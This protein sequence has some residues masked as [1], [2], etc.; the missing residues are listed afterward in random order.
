VSEPVQIDVR[1][2]IAGKSPALLRV[3][4]PVVIRLLE[5]II[6]SRDL[7]RGLRLLHDYSGVEFARQTLLL[8]GARVETIGEEHVS[9]VKRPLVVAN[10]PLGGLDGLALIDVVGRHHE[11]VVLPVNDLL[12]NIPQLRPVF[13]PINKHGSNRAYREKFDLAFAE[14][15]AVVHFPAGLCSRRK[16]DRIRDLDWQKSFVPRARQ[17]ERTIVPTHVEGA[18]S[19]FFYNL[20]RLRRWTGLR[21]NIEM[22]FL[23]HE[24][25]RQRGRTIRI[26]FGRP[27]SAGELPS[28][29]DPWMIARMLK[30]HVYRLSEDPDAVFSP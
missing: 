18:N 22:I 11:L 26:T 7:N 5:R 4:P 30:S 17:T 9:S 27:V 3:L 15:D 25:F 28:D 13:V 19:R 23:V 24:M 8:L 16:G 6:H 20:A 29:M 1:R 14:A 21:A 2:I 10:H 12:M